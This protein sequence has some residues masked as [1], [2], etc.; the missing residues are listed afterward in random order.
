MVSETARCNARVD[1]HVAGTGPV[2]RLLRG[3]DANGHALYKPTEFVARSHANRQDFACAACPPRVLVHLSNLMNV[4]ATSFIDG[5]ITTS[6]DEIDYSPHLNI[7]PRKYDVFGV[8]VSSTS[9]ADVVEALI[10]AANSR[11][12]A[13]V[14]FT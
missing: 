6:L 4:N 9:Y 8:H 10:K 12:P 3:L 1:L 14:D 13:L 11:I 2:P 7:W 5:N